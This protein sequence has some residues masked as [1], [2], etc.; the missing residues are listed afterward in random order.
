VGILKVTVVV[1]ALTTVAFQKLLALAVPPQ[2]LLGGH[3]AG[4]DEPLNDTWS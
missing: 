3:R 4:R 2:P 1:V